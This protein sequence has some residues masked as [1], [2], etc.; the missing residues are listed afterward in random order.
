MGLD[1]EPA[2]HAEDDECDREVE[3]EVDGGCLIHSVVSCLFGTWI[4]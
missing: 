1:G 4:L 2:D 3:A